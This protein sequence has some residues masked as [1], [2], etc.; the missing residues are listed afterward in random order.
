MVT[1]KSGT[2][3]TQSIFVFSDLPLNATCERGK[4]EAAAAKGEKKHESKGEV[5]KKNL[6]GLAITMMLMVVSAAPAVAQYSGPMKVKVP[7][8]FVVENDRLPA[9]EYSIQRVSNGWLRIQSLDDTRRVAT[10]LATPKL[11]KAPEDKA[12]FLFHCY[13]SEHFLTAIWTPG[14]NMGW[15]VLEGKLEVEVARHAT[16]PV[17][18]AMV[19]GR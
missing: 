4:D 9:G 10:F 17:E 8:A 6:A 15:E 13:G 14:L 1:R 16:A 2:I 19:L 12:H 11:G 5:M 7:F 18:T 3:Q